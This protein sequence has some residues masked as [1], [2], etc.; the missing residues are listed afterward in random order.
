M[1]ETTRVTNQFESQAP[2]N[3]W[4]RCGAPPVG[5]NLWA[6]SCRQVIRA[7]I[8]EQ[9]IYCP[10]FSNSKAKPGPGVRF[11]KYGSDLPPCWWW[12][13]LHLLDRSSTLS[14]VQATPNL[15]SYSSEPDPFKVNN[16][17]KLIR[18]LGEASKALERRKWEEDGY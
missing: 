1:S 17:G 4:A 10:A 11:Q 9:L 13:W 6:S 7:A 16:F 3:C 15:W 14:A 5:Y 2:R 18:S 8:W 12:I